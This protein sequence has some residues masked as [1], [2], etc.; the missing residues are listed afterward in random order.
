MKYA[1]PRLVVNT[2]FPCSAIN[3]IAHLL[4]PYE[5]VLHRHI[6]RSFPC[7]RGRALRT[8]HSTC[9][10]CSHAAGSSHAPQDH[11]IGPRRCFDI[12]LVDLVSL[13]S[14]RCRH[15]APILP[16]DRMPQ[17]HG[18]AVLLE[19]LGCAKETVPSLQAFLASNYWWTMLV[20][21]AS[22]AAVREV[23][24]N[25]RSYER[26]RKE[27][28]RERPPVAFFAGRTEVFPRCS[29]VLHVFHRRSSCASLTVLQTTL[30]R[31]CQPFSS[32]QVEMSAAWMPGAPWACIEAGLARG[33]SCGRG[34]SS[35]MTLLRC[36]NSAPFSSRQQTA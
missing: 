23:G 22:I 12:V 7:V 35:H 34:I 18:L 5:A 19:D 14:P 29:S 9:A 4:G 26:R 6:R 31:Q 36:I 15:S 27:D 32:A 1:S 13:S 11:D 33:R 25:E 10:C 20:R 21:G 3:L 17:D 2:M 8:L 30:A 24:A 16:M 28:R